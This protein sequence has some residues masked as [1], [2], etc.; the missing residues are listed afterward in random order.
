MG[1]I[2]LNSE[3]YS[4]YKDEENCFGSIEE[5]ICFD[6]DESECKRCPDKKLCEEI[7]NADSVT[8]IIDGSKADAAEVFDT[9]PTETKFEYNRENLTESLKKMINAT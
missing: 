2:I 6:P 1:K 9:E 4:D 8:E 5:G 3:Q 7:H